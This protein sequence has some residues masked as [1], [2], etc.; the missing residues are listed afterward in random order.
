MLLAIF[1]ILLIL[2][3]LGVIG[4]F[5][6]GGVLHLLLVVALVALVVGLADTG[7]RGRRFAFKV[8][9]GM[10]VAGIWFVLTG[11]LGLFGFTFEGQALLMAVL[12]LVAGILLLLGR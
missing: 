3:F 2:W 4:N 10:A 11:L 7:V 9:P 12:A 6:F 1:V 5:T 8:N